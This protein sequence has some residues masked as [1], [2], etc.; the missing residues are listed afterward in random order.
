MATNNWE[1]FFTNPPFNRRLIFNIYKELKKLDF[2]KLNN[3]IRKWS[4]E[5]DK[6][7][8]PDKY[9]MKE[10]NLKKC[11]KS[12]V[13]KEMQIKT[14]LRFQLIPV[15]MNNIK[16]SGDSRCMQGYGGR[17]IILHYWWF[18]KMVQPHGNQS[19]G[20]SENWT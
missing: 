2:R 14:T 8:S 19:G 12:L 5:L 7:I 9:Q 1:K 15:R 10:K 20:F 16:N 18:C 11:S 17:G 6:E 4:T 3:T 13:I